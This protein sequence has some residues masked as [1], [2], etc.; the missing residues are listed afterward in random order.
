[1]ITI[2]TAG[3]IDHGKSSLIKALTRIDPDRLPE[4]KRRGMTIDLG[5]AWLKLPS[6]DTVGIVDVPGH[7]HFVANVIPGL[8]GIDAA[9]LVV[10]ADDG[11]M[12]QTEE[13]VQIIDLLGIKKGIIA[14]TKIDLATDTEWLALVEKDIRQRIDATGLA[15]TPIVRVSSRD[16]RGLDKLKEAIGR[17]ASV[18]ASRRDIGKPRLPVDRVFT[19][20]GSGV[21]VT[22]TLSGGPLSTGDDVVISPGNLPA[23]LR[24]VESYTQKEAKV[25][26]GTRVALNL[27]GVKKED[28][29]RGDVIMARGQQTPT[30]RLID[31]KLRLLPGLDKPL[32]SNSEL[33]VFLE[34][35]ELLGRVV[36]LDTKV[37]QP[38]GSALAQLRL[39]EDVATYI[40]QQFVLRSQSPSMTVGGGIVLD[41]TSRKHRLKEVTSITA[42]LK[43][44]V[45]TSLEDLVLTELEKSSYVEI[46]ELLKASLYSAA[47]ISTCLGELKEGGKIIVAGAFV[48]DSGYWQKQVASVL[49][50]L[51]EEHSTHPLKAGLSQAELLSRLAM[52]R[53]V[54]GQLLAGLAAE[55]KIV[56]KGET[57]ALSGHQT[58]PSPQQ[59]RQV[60]QVLTL[61]TGSGSNPPTKKELASQLHGSGDVIRYMRHQGMLVELPDGILLKAEKYEAA[62]EAIITFLEKNGRISI[63]DVNSLLGFSRKYSIPLL[64]RL[65]Q[66]GI[67]RR[68]ENV[69]VLVK[70]RS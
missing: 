29:A 6:G 43:R 68:K 55:G 7:K 49:D 25:R 56:I 19:M 17:L 46:D 1:M 69:R 50:I 45:K 36:L 67:T 40:G 2:G 60:E 48:V 38:G 28:L 8:G 53:E 51:T 58:R 11:W 4:E 32:K 44:R 12:P 18:M 63:Q 33:A 61:F 65:D 52:P 31:V 22:G 54:F 10:A 59:Q 57:A 42:F 47:E 23:H 26:P 70:K 3:H 21:V 62:R 5:F 27:A 30:G 34:T 39:N 15:G 66:E 64:T 9:L 13:H 24:S 37:L 16:G 35:R 41:P 20:K 14:L